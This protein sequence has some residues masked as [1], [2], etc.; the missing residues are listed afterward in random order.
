MTDIIER[1]R[2]AGD[3]DEGR[4]YSTMHEAADEVERLREHIAA[5]QL[6]ATAHEA[7]IERLRAQLAGIIE[8]GMDDLTMV[9][10]FQVNEELRAEIERLR[11]LLQE[12]IRLTLSAEHNKISPPKWVIEARR[13]LEPKP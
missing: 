8:K 13:E 7:E 9:A 10:A 4:P 12:A 2:V 5:L 6:A 1:L 3:R 11:A